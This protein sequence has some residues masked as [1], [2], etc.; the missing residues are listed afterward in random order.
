[1]PA[2]SSSSSSSSSQHSFPNIFSKGPRRGSEPSV[3][4]AASTPIQPP[5]NVSTGLNNGQGVYN[6]G[7]IRP[8]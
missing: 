3:A 8:L 5:G 2:S 6:I 1:M 4:F 7:M